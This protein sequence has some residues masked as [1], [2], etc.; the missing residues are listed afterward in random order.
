V[1]DGLHQMNQ[2]IAARNSGATMAAAVTI[3]G[4]R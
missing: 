3:V 2:L 4:V 1:T